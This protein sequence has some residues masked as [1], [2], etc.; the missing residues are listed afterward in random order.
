[1]S[2]NSNSLGEQAHEALANQTALSA[3]RIIA[4]GNRLH[5]EVFKATVSMC[6]RCDAD[7]MGKLMAFVE[8]DEI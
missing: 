1:M 5:Q 3:M 4:G 6:L 8:H 7:D 2:R